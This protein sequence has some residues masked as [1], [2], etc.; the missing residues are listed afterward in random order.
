MGSGY[1]VASID[2]SLL[3]TATSSSG[4]GAVFDII[5]SPK[6]GHGA[7]PTEELGGNYVIAN[8]RLEYAEG[9]GDFPTDNDFRQIGLIVNPTDA[10]GNT[11]SSATTL[12]A[13]N[14]ITLNVGATM[15]VVDD[16]IANAASVVAGTAVGKVVSIDS[17][18]RYIYFLPS[19]DAVGNFNNFSA[20]NS[21]FVGST[22]KGTISSGGV[23]GSY[24][25]VS[26]N[27]GDI[28]YLENRGAVARAADQIEDIKLIIEM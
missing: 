2:N 25:E 4:T 7:D 18:N 23:S 11:L 24:P 20:A 12:S 5:I 21:V 3:Q 9:S 8:S 15:P 28:V 10:G 1:S 16:T 14:R 6:N 13:L 22:S 19:V 17:T 27:S 26:R